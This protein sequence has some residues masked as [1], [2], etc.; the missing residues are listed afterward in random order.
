MEINFSEI[1]FTVLN[2]FIIYFFLRKILFVPVTKLMNDRTSAIEKQINEAEINLKESEEMKEKYNNILL[3]SESEGKSIVE[4][5]KA[6]GLSLY[7]EIVE[8]ARKEA[9]AIRQ[10]ARLDADREKEKANDEIRRQIVSLSLLAASKALE[11][12]LDREKHHVLIKEF[13]NKAGV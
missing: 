3:Q 8:E 12:Q 5:Y 7:D 13:I 2:V 9:E 11:S 4:E 1:F 10:R 6:K